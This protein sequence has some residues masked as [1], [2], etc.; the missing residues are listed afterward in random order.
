[1]NKWQTN[2]TFKLIS[3]HYMHQVETLKINNMQVIFN[4]EIVEKI[5]SKYHCIRQVK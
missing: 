1:M 3:Y 4:F 5:P 2:L